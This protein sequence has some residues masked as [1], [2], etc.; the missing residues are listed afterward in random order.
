MTRMR[1]EIER[2][3]EKSFF[4][5]PLHPAF[6][7]VIRVPLHLD[8]KIRCYTPSSAEFGVQ[9]SESFFNSALRTP[10]SALITL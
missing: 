3:G 4:S 5:D 6:F 2:I 10:N 7:R 8:S 1:P 9:S